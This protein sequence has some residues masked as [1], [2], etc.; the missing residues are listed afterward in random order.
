MGRCTD[1][2]HWA[3]VCRSR[4]SQLRDQSFRATGARL[5]L[6]SLYRN[7]RAADGP[8]EEPARSSPT[9]SGFRG[10]DTV[11]NLD[12]SSASGW[13][14]PAPRSITETG[15]ATEISP[16]SSLCTARRTMNDDKPTLK[17]A[18]AR[19]IKSST[20]QCSIGLLC[21]GPAAT[22]SPKTRGFAEIFNPRSYQLKISCQYR[23]GPGLD[24]SGRT[25]SCGREG[26]TRRR[27]TQNCFRIVGFS[28]LYL[29]LS[30]NRGDSG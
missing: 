1:S 23:P 12:A 11:A 27:G 16:R 4:C 17:T 9:S 20:R 30:R 18:A 25:P 10:P 2:R 14:W 24:P 3:D 5:S 26:K 13:Q 6:L 7:H 28:V 22:A 19:F 29:S 8:W 15:S 21:D